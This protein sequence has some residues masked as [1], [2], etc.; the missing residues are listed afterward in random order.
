[1]ENT[2]ESRAEFLVM[3]CGQPYRVC[4]DKYPEW[5]EQLMALKAGSSEETKWLADFCTKAFTLPANQPAPAADAKVEESVRYTTKAID[6]I[7]QAFA[8]AWRINAVTATLSNEQWLKDA[9]QADWEAFASTV[10]PLNNMPTWLE[11]TAPASTVPT[12]VSVPT[13][14]DLPP[15]PRLQD[16]TFDPVRAAFEEGWRCSGRY[17]HGAHTA[18][19]L[20][21]QCAEH[22]KGYVAVIGVQEPSYRLGAR[23]SELYRRQKEAMAAELLRT[24]ALF[25]NKADSIART[26]MD[27]AIEA[28]RSDG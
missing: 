13:A 18:A 4:R 5:T 20:S 1:M 7:R 14:A 24:S 21:G 11:L 22:L 26:L 17:N 8:T 12:P 28:S 3:F 15:Q 25:A 10:A 2:Y 27:I 19:F 23:G 9:E 16:L 6:V